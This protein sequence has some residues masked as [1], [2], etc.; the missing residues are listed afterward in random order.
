MVVCGIG[1]EL[2]YQTQALNN[3]GAIFTHSANYSP[4]HFGPNEMYMIGPVKEQLQSEMN[5]YELC[6]KWGAL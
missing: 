1:A 6:C 2:L 3:S 4:F 5:I